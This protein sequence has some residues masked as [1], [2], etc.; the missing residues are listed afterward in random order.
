MTQSS[1]PSAAA[2]GGEPNWAWLGL[3]KW[4]LQYTDG[5]VPSE[6]SKN[7]QEM[8]AEDKQ[9]LEEVMKNGII[10]EGERMSVILE[11]LVSHMESIQNNNN[12]TD[13][14]VDEDE[15]IELLEE[16]R[17]IVE[18]IDYAKAFAS[19]GGLQFLIGC[20]SERNG[21]P[22]S[23]RSLCLNV[24][25][26]LCQNNPV[27]QLKMLELGNL[28]K[29]LDIYFSSAENKES[30]DNTEESINDCNKVKC[31]AIQALSSCVRNHDVAEKI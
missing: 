26:T 27:V 14:S 21:V 3:L 11:N 31:S 5:T 4:S 2:E 24:T 28:V 8:S 9:F 13:E 6:E 25:S 7:Y 12:N 17:D 22:T 20:A 19:M 1:A 30:D 16:L 18:Q 29:L 15:V 10:N 23:V